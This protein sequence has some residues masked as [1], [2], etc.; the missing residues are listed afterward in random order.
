MNNRHHTLP[1]SRRAIFRQGGLTLVE[2]MVAITI[3]LVLLAGVVQIF[4]SNKVTYRVQENL[5][6]IQE[7][8]R[9]AVD[10]LARSL[11]MTAWQGDTPGEWVLGSLS[12]SNGGVEALAGTNNDT[13]SGPTSASRG[14]SSSHGSRN[15]VH[16]LTLAGSVWPSEAWGG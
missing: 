7:N 9:F 10:L 3:S 2:L 15:V 13:A 6:R 14:E 5:G 11:R 4:L 1:G 16:D 8:G 12:M